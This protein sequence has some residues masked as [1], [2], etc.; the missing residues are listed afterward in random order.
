MFLRIVAGRY[1]PVPQV[2]PPPP[3]PRPPRAATA[4]MNVHSRPA[5]LPGMFAEL[6]QHHRLFVPAFYEM[7][8]DAIRTSTRPHLLLS[9]P[10]PV[11]TFR[12]VASRF[13]GFLLRVRS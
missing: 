10:S 11:G 5:L 7:L 4:S 1:S 8:F 6:L 13:R 12:H 2:P 3:P 9:A